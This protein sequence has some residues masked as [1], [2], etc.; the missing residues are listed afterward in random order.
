M[1]NYFILMLPFG[2]MSAEEVAYTFDA[3]TTE[4]MPAVREAEPAAAH[5]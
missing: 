3:F 2:D 1:A 4:V 5:A